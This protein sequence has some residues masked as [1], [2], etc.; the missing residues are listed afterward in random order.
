MSSYFKQAISEQVWKETYKWDTD[1][2]FESSCRRVAKAVASIEKDKEKYEKDF[3]EL[4]INKKYVPA[5]R[6]W[7]NAGTGLKKTTL[8]NCFVSGFEGKNQDSIE[9]IYKE[10]GRQAKILSSEGDMV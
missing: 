7:S 10:L 9:G 6:I 1:E 4:L 5:G 3:F 8:I 2:N